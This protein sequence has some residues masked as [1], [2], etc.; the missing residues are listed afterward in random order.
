QL[1]DIPKQ[2]VIRGVAAMQSLKRLVAVP[3]RGDAGRE[4]RLGLRC[5]HEGSLRSGVIERLDSETITRGKE[6][7]RALVPKTKSELAPEALKTALSEFFMEVKRD[8]AVSAR[9]EAVASRF[10]LLSD[11]VES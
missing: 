10:Q 2:R 4:E 11:G 7:R 9:R 8:L 6:R 5:Q 3:G 1:L